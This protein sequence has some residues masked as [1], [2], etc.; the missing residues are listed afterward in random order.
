MNWG[1]KPGITE[2]WA[3]AP[4]SSLSYTVTATLRGCFT[5][6]LW[7]QFLSRCREGTEV[8]ID[9]GQRKE[10][11]GHSPDS[12]QDKRSVKYEGPE[13][14]HSIC[15]LLL[16]LINVFLLFTHFQYSQHLHLWCTLKW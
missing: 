14:I 11:W 9:S 5:A 7:F 13:C 4:G 16:K 1:R 12:G 15:V 8:L 6:P 10:D 3:D 2:A